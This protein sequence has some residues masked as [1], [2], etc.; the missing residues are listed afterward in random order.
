MSGSRDRTVR[1]WDVNRPE[2]EPILLDDHAAW[3]ETVG[4]TP[5]SKWVLTGS[6][7]RTI[8]IFPVSPD[9]MADRICEKLERSEMTDEEWKKYVGEDIPK[10]MVCGGETARQ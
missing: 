10:T 1:V 4:F 7:D 8:K 2:E 9:G 3:V 6:R 5:D